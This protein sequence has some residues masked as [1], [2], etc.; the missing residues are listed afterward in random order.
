[1][2]PQNKPINTTISNQAHFSQL[3]ASYSEILNTT[4]ISSYQTTNVPA[5]PCHSSTN[6]KRKSPY[7]TR[8]LKKPSLTPAKTH[9]SPTQSS[10]TNPNL[11]IT[12][13]RSNPSVLA[14]PSKKGSGVPLTSI[15][16]PILTQPLILVF[17]PGSSEKLHVRSMFKADRE[18]KNKLVSVVV[19]A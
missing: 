11:Q 7:N 15:E 18:G 2:D 9:L 12:R 16:P 4:A 14:S 3:K 17:T 13:K 10:H 1:V 5:K 6:Y 8:P 19:A